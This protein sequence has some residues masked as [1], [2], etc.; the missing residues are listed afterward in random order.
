MISRRQALKQCGIVGGLL[1]A[2]HPLRAPALTNHAAP[3]MLTIGP[4]KHG[5]KVPADFSG[6]SY[7]AAQLVDPGY[8]SPGNKPLVGL[9]RRLGKV[10]VLR[11]GGNTS[12]LAA[13]TQGHASQSTLTKNSAS[14]AITPESIRNLAGFL[15]ATGWRLIYGL[16]LG[17]GTPAEAVEEAAFVRRQW[18]SRLLALQIGNEPDVFG[19]RLRPHVKWDFY[20]LRAMAYLRAASGCR[21]GC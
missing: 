15:D 12:D 6:L 16:N 1:L 7:E 11:I 3:L 21:C 18:G 20:L 4:A 17:T 5:R 8:F 14:V 9:V 19:G 2:S 13:W 10:G